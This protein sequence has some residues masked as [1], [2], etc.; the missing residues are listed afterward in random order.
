MENDSIRKRLAEFNTKAYYLLVAPAAQRPHAV[1][2]SEDGIQ[3]FSTK[4]GPYLVSADVLAN[5][6]S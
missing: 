3:A 6:N 1:S 4:E 5:Y 2:K